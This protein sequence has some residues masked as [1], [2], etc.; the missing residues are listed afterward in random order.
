HSFIELE[1]GSNSVPELGDID[2][3]DDLDLLVGESGGG[4]HFY[5]NNGTANK[6]KFV[7]EKKAFPG[8]EADHRSAPA[9]VDIDDDGDLDL[10]LGT[11]TE[12]LLFFE[13]TGSAN[14]AVFTP[15]TLSD[16]IKVPRLSTPEFVDLNGDGQM[17]FLSGG[18][19][20]GLIYY[21]LLSE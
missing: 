13:N 2:N 18:D 12:G 20:G 7:L 19:G 11:Q 3:D 21:R 5:R 10:F 8:V 14:E 9:L 16:S 1:R 6:P 4:I 15:S 17:E